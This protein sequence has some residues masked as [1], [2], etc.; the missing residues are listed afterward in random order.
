[1]TT[2]IFREGS[3]PKSDSA[4]R[5]A[6][7]QWDSWEEDL[8]FTLDQRT[9][10]GLLAGNED[11]VEALREAAPANVSNSDSNCAFNVLIGLLWAPAE[12]L[13]PHS[14]Q[15][16]VRFVSTPPQTER[17]LVRDALETQRQKISVTQG[18]W[19]T[20]ADA[21]LASQGLCVLTAATDNEP[22]L[23]DALLD[24]MVDPIEM[25]WLHLH[26]RLTGIRRHLEGVDALVELVEAPQ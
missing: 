24:L 26:P 3:S 4:I 8:K 7:N 21:Q 16:H 2:R 15:T 5:I 19:R 14:L 10:C 12:F 20:L 13:R 9:A 1:M 25:G 18:Q 17:T 22:A 11:V 23:R 6:L